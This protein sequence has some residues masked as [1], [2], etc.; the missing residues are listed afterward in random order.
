LLLLDL[1][2]FEERLRLELEDLFTELDLELPELVRVTFEDLVL[3]DPELL[4]TDPDER[5]LDELDFTLVL[6]LEDLD[7]LRLVTPVER[8]VLT[9]VEELLVLETL[10]LAL[11]ETEDPDERVL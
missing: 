8:E 11:L 4:D 5:L 9:L 2:T 1:L 3:F 10:L 7:E 6:E